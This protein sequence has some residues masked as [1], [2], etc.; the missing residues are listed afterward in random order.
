MHAEHMPSEME[1]ALREFSKSSSNNLKLGEL[2]QILSL[3]CQEAARPIVLIIDEKL[4]GSVMISN[5]IFETRLYNLFLS[6]SEVQNSAMV[7]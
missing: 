4:V 2:F 1:E 6:A 7:V 5:R 3:W